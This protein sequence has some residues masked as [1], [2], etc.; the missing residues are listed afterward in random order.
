MSP[1]TELLEL[2][3]R[4]A[5]ENCELAYDISLKELHPE[6][7]IY[8][9]LGSGFSDTAYFNKTAVR[10]IPVLFL[11]R[12][13]DQQKGMEQLCSICNYLQ[14][15]KTYPQGETV[16]WLDAK[17]ATEPNKIGRDEDGKYNFSC[18]VNCLI[19]F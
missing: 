7:G 11:C 18:I 12:D 13:T 19:Y 4:T 17:V 1:Q 14:K 10:T 2:I 8:A 5:E 6:G 15:L 9:E 3:C 16:S